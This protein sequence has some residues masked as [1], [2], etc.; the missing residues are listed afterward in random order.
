MKN[1]LKNQT[2]VAASIARSSGFDHTYEALINIVKMLEKDSQVA[3]P[4][5]VSAIV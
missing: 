2:L 5:G 1:E 4:I 3:S